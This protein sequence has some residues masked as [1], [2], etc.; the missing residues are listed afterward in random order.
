MWKC[1]NVTNWAG[2]T[3]LAATHKSHLIPH[4]S[5]LIPKKHFPLSTLHS[6]LK[7]SPPGRSK[8]KVLKKL[9]VKGNENV[10]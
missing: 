7:K 1:A 2:A 4:T 5:Y 6:P 10:K 3:A 9:I 8:K